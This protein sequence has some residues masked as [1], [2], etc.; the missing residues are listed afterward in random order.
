MKST[1][2]VQ[3][4]SPAI[5]AAAAPSD[6]TYST[7]SV[8]EFSIN[9]SEN[10]KVTG[11]PRIPLTLTPGTNSLIFRY[12]TTPTDSD[13]DGIVMGAIDLNGGSIKDLVSY[14]AILN[15]TPPNTS[16][17]MLTSNALGVTSITIVP[18]FLSSRRQRQKLSFMFP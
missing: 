3:S 6:G 15:F 11:N 8:L 14:E 13:T 5:S 4:D 9:F 17:I 18:H 7:G 16:A 12:T 10:V 2:A 1:V